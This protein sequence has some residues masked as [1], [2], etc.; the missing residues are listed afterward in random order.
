MPLF[1]SILFTVGFAYWYYRTAE[2]LGSKAMHWA[3]A[4]AIAYQVP[5]WAWMV[6]VSR[7]Y[8]TSIRGIA[9]KTGFTSFLVGHSWILVGA[10]CAFVVF[11]LFLLRTKVRAD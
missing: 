1:I 8:L 9:A 11:R 5:A 7:P 4:G 10:V 6:L 2:R 3:V